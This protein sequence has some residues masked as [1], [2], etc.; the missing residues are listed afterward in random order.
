MLI[1]DIV[2]KSNMDLDTNV[3]YLTTFDVYEL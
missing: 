2:F 1:Q 3:E